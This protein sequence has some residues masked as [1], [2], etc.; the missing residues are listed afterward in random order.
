MYL[1]ASLLHELRMLAQHLFGRETGPRLRPRENSAMLCVG[2]LR[3][4]KLIP[5][6]AIAIS[7]GNSLCRE[8]II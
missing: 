8:H 7:S 5:N 1:N 6:K 4:N 3:S 2:C